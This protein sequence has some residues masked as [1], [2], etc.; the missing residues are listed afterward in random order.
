VVLLVG[1][2]TSLAALL[3]GRFL[4]GVVSGVVFS[5]GSAWLTELVA[6]AGVASRRASAAMSLGFSLGPLSAGFLGQFAPLPDVLSYLVHVLFIAVALVLVARAPETVAD[7]RRR[8]R[9]VNLGV[10]TRARPAFLAFVV[11]A[12]LLVF[13]FPSIAV[14]VLP[15]GLEAAMP[16]LE[17]VATGLVAGTTL[18]VGVLVQ[19]L[20]RRLGLARSA[21]LGA[22]SGG[23]GLLL[24]A[25][26]MT[27]EQPLLL[28]PVS[29][30]L[31]LGYGLS[32]PAGLTATQQL[33]D[34]AHR[35]AL[36]STYLALTYLGFGTPVVL[37][38]VSDGL[39]FVPALLAFASIAIAATLWLAFGPGARWVAARHAETVAA[40][41]H[42][43]VASPGQP[44]A[45]APP[46]G[47][48]EVRR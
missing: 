5:V 22:A 16:G 35:G 1:A 29:L 28:L 30:L 20:A 40:A 34:P 38:A 32:L 25:V 10:P 48:G 24:G 13:T 2:S 9:W 43:G 44:P 42:P 11:P 39:D 3:A 47:E 8:G 14:T 23:V 21:S 12:A 17:L 36:T 27:A 33:A 18:G 26:A 4:Q 37:S 19:P 7:R 41:G 45:V 31:G 15:L 6:D 46:R